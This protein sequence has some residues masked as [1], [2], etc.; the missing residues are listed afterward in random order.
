MNPQTRKGPDSNGG[1]L[2]I[3]Y[4]LLGFRAPRPFQAPSRSPGLSAA[5][6]LLEVAL[7]LLFAW[8]TGCWD[9]PSL[10]RSCGLA[11]RERL[12]GHLGLSESQS[13]SLENGTSVLALLGD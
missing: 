1:A 12:G 7:L 13:P 5:A 11:A 4:H 8:G 6:S 2:F 3:Y 10:D 9:G